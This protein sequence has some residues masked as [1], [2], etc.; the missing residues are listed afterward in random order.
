MNPIYIKY[1]PHDNC[2]CYAIDLPWPRYAK[3]TLILC[4]VT[5]GINSARSTAIGYVTEHFIKLTY[6]SAPTFKNEEE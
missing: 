4:P 3:H 5:Q 2:D 6:E 1:S